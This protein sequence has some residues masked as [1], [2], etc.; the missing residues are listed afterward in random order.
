MSKQSCTAYSLSDTHTTEQKSVRAGFLNKL[1]EQN[2]N[3]C[4][5]Y[6][7]RNKILIDKIIIYLN[8]MLTHQH[9]Q[10]NE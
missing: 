5:F 3:V 1:L 10:L 9:H 2:Q 8:I 7:N 4:M 6:Y